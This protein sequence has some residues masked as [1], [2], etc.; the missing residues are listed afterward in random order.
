MFTIDKPIEGIWDTRRNY[1]TR[2]YVIHEVKWNGIVIVKSTS[3]QLEIRCHCFSRGSLSIEKVGEAKSFMIEISISFLE[4][5]HTARV[6][7]RGKY[8]KYQ[9]EGYDLFHI[10]LERNGYDTDETHSN[11]IRI[12]SR[13]I[14]TCNSSITWNILV[15][16]SCS[17]SKIYVDH[18][19]RSRLVTIRNHDMS[20]RSSRTTVMVI[21]NEW[22][23][24]IDFID[25][26]DPCTPYSS[27]MCPIRDT[28]ST[29]SRI[30]HA[31]C[32]RTK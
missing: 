14:R 21:H 25:D 26:A 32:D 13:N 20:T 12:N 10:I 17:P 19:T 24:C 28:V 2:I 3:C 5:K 29:I 15:R 1:E 30:L 22:S 23:L 11:N 16:E 27:D 9:K 18:F 8:E 31:K 7:R 6:D 4:I